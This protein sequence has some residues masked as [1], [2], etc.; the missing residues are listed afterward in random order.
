[1]VLSAGLRKVSKSHPDFLPVQHVFGTSWYPLCI[2]CSVIEVGSRA[3]E[4]FIGQPEPF[5]LPFGTSESHRWNPG[6]GRPTVFGSKRPLFN[7]LR[8]AESG[9]VLRTPKRITQT[10]P[11]TLR[12]VGAGASHQSLGFGSGPRAVWSVWV[13]QHMNRRQNQK[14]RSMKERYVFVFVG[15]VPGPLAVYD[16]IHMTRPY[17]SW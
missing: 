4:M 8:R 15:D 16:S 2:P 14:G 13:E 1:M 9:P 17:D 7:V 6:S 5:R 3:L 12:S 11:W 10:R